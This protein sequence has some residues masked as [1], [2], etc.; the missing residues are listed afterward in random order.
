M[1][2]IGDIGVIKENQKV[3]NIF[4]VISDGLL[5]ICSIFIAYI[6][7][8]R[9]FD[10]LDNIGLTYYMKLAVVSTPVFLF[11]Y[12]MLGLYESFRAKNFTTE[13]ELLLQANLIGTIFLLAGQFVLRNINLSRG[14][15]AIFFFASTGMIAVKRLA[16]RRTLRHYRSLG[17]NQKHVLIVGSNRT[18]TQYYNIITKD[19]TLG[20][21]PVGQIADKGAKIGKLR[22]LGDFA[23]LGCVLE[24]GGIDEV[25]AAL[26]LEENDHISQIIHDCEKYGVKLSLIPFYAD[27]MSAHPYIDEVGGL[28][29]MNIRRIPLDN[30]AN[31]AMKRVMDICGA[32]ILIVLTSPIML[33]AAIGVRLSSPGPIIFKQ[34]RVGLNKKPFFMYK[35]RSMRVNDRQDSGWSRDADPRR[36]KFGALIRKCSID[37]LP[38]FFNVLKGD[39]SLVG[40]RPEVPHF[41]NQ[42][43]ETIPLYMVKHQVRPGITGWAQVNGLR[44]DTSIEERIRHDIFYIENW[45]LLLDIKILLMTVSKALINAEKFSEPR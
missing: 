14:L 11:L 38:Q 40:P 10:G 15:L 20:L 44:G 36:T 24:K 5:V 30:L 33:F 45:S 25:V 2:R 29:L 43:K 9:I 42:F 23:H 41:V 22:R 4:N 31:A 8:F 1:K 12:A 39:M 21:S 17:Y 34:E 28:P 35:F 6:I 26:S 13:L 16:L 3:L 27:Y 32:L 18:A 7:R 19:L 37:E